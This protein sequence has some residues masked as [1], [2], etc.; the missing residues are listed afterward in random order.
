MYLYFFS[1]FFFLG[2]LCAAPEVQQNVVDLLK[3]KLNSDR[4]EYF[5][6]SYG[7]DPLEIESPVFPNSRIANLHSLHQGKKIMRTLAVVDYFQPQQPSLGPVHREIVQGKSIGIALREHGW[8]IHKNAVYF[9]SLSLSPNVM[10]WMD[11]YESKEG[12]VHFYRLEVSKNNQDPIPYCTILELHSP[13][14]LTQEWLQALYAEQ[15]TE[16]SHQ[17]KEASEFINRLA[18]LLQ[19]FPAATN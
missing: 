7:V 19:D 18:L 13:Q 14:Y 16:Y 6:G 5:F 10:D 9:G 8:T 2:T 12:A 15:Y 1:C 3:P 11:E 4:I 17:S